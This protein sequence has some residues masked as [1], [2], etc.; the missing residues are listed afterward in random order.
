MNVMRNKVTVISL[1]LLGQFTLA[2]SAHAAKTAEEC[3]QEDATIAEVSRCLDGVIETV[4]RELQT[5]VNNHVFN[6]EEKAMLTGRYSTLKMF[7]RSQSNFI[8]FRENDCR[9]QYLA[10]SPEKGASIAYKKCYI[11]VSQARI[12][13]LSKIP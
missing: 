8:T 5:W 4:D 2:A 10:V 13:Q 3:Q 6:L 11:Q 12:T 7:K 9:W 1:F